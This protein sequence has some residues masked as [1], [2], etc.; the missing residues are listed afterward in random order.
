MRCWN[1][2]SEG[3]L[4]SGSLCTGRTDGTLILGCF[5]E[6][7]YWLKFVFFC[8]IFG[9]YSRFFE[10]WTCNRT[11]RCFCAWQTFSPKSF[12]CH[13]VRKRNWMQKTFLSPD[14]ISENIITIFYQQSSIYLE[15]GIKTPL[16]S[17]YYFAFS[18]SQGSQI[19]K[20]MWNY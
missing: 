12:F 2:W 3:L 6:Y 15:D 1:G 4:G 17:I 20:P 14:F 9:P 7:I 16:L 13:I 8:L 5:V 10:F 18:D 19:L 11:W